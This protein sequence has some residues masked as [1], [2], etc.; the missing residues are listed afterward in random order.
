MRYL[1]LIA[2]LAGC[3]AQQTVAL[4]PRAGGPSGTGVFDQMHQV[5]TVDIEGKRYQGTPIS[6]TATTSYSIFSAGSTTSSNEQSALLIGTAGQVRCDF[7]W[8]Q[9]RTMATGSCIDSQN[10]T[11]DLLIKN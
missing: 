9:F 5:L 2:L 7:T 3:A 6:K 4:L 1:A 11:Y 10:A 8:N